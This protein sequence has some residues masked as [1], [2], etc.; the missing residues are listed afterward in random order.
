[1]GRQETIR[2]FFREN[3]FSGLF[4]LIPVWASLYVLLK[5]SEWLYRKL[6][7]LPL[8]PEQLLAPV[9]KTLPDW[10]VFWVMKSLHLA[11]FLVVLIAL[12]TFISLIGLIAKWRLFNWFLNRAESV[13][14][15]IP[16]IGTIYSALQQLMT[17][18]FSG[19]GSFTQVVLVEFPR[20]G[21]WSMG[22]RSRDPDPDIVKKAGVG[23]LQSVFIPT[24]P[25]PTTGFLVMLPPDKVHPVDISIEGAFKMI[26]SGG[27]AQP[28]EQ[29]EPPLKKLRRTAATAGAEKVEK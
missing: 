1:M 14:R 21:L 12:F 26:M 10:A 2:K 19:Q 13:L 23:P 28:E 27:M 17:A 20:E 29:L 8:V 24:T 3:F 22:F 6:V 4:I 9:L 16:L 7:I 5:I 11:E 15:R 25:N 18:L